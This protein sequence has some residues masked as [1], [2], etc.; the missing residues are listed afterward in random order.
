M[1]ICQ[2]GQIITVPRYGAFVPGGEDAFV[3]LAD[4]TEVDRQPTRVADRRWE[5]VA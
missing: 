3:S 2:N 1:M 4:R 5:R